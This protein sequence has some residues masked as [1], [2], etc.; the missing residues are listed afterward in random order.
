MQVSDRFLSKYNLGNLPG[1][2]A[3]IAIIALGL[4]FVLLLGEIDLSAGTAGGTCA[5]HRRPGR[6]L[7][8]P[9]PGACPA[10]STG[11]WWSGSWPPSRWPCG[12]RPGPGR[13]SWL[14]GLVLVAT[15]LTQHLFLALVA[16]VCIGA[17]IGVLNGYLVAK[18]GIPSF[19]VTLA[20]FLAWQGVLQFV[21][22]RPADQH[23]QL[24]AVA[25][26]DLRQPQPHLELG[27]LDRGGGRLHRLH[28]ASSR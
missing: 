25:Q 18:V 27:L 14:L 21:A 8:Q 23:V 17:A 2:G 26:H 7:G 11:A 19:V 13:P 3:Y 5:A 20:L 9:P 6:L 4:V 1:Q 16:A 28:R 10:P 22:E 12:S 24:R 15:N